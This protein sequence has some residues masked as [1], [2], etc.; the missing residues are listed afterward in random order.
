MKTTAPIPHVSAL[1]TCIAP[2]LGV[3][4]ALSPRA[5]DRAKEQVARLI[6]SVTSD[7]V[8]KLDACAGEPCSEG[9]PIAPSCTSDTIVIVYRR[10]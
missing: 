7:F 8:G 6:S 5:G 10:E 4:S 3:P 9:G 2:V 1:L